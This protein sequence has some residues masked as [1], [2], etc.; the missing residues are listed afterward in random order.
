M[1]QDA[2]TETKKKLDEIN[3]IAKKKGK[4]VVDDLLGAVVN[5]VPEPAS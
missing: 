5:V 3:E 2:E 4:K 1:E